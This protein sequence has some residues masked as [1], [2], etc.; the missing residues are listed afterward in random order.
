MSKSWE[1]KLAQRRA[2]RE[3]VVESPRSELAP[4]PATVATPNPVPA[5]SAAEQFAWTMRHH[6]RKG[7]QQHHR[8]LMRLADAMARAIKGGSVADWAAEHRGECLDALARAGVLI[9]GLVYEGPA[10]A[11]AAW[12]V[13]AQGR[14]GDPEAAME[15]FERAKGKGRLGHLPKGG[16][17]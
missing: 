13:F 1:E 15:A 14:P 7:N 2:E 12:L 11:S 6:G 3:K 4:T 8:D 9:D 16:V 5:M 17:P 10:L